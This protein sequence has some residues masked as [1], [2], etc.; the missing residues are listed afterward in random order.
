[1]Y[2]NLSIIV[3]MKQVSTITAHVQITSISHNKQNS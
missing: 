1:M 2:K 3:Q